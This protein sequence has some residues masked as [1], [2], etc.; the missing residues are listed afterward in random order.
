MTMN[1]HHNVGRGSENLQMG[2]P[3]MT[4]I[5]DMTVKMK[6]PVM[7]VF[8]K[9]QIDVDMLG[10]DFKGAMLTQLLKQVEVIMDE[11]GQNGELTC[12]PEDKEWMRVN[13]DFFGPD[14]DDE[15]VPVE[16]GK[17]IVAST[18]DYVIRYELDA[19][20]VRAS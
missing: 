20:K 11:P 6:T 16:E 18:R 5:L 3:R 8:P 2:V 7:V 13:R 19:D 9:E 15:D 14:C 4:E 17:F 1:T 10:G 12:V